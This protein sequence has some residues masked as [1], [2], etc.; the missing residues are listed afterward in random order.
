M[1]FCR[2]DCVRLDLMKIK[3]LKK[4]LCTLLVGTSEEVGKAACPPFCDR[5]PNQAATNSF[6]VEPPEGVEPSYF[7]CIVIGIRQESA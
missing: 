2:R 1:P 4:P 5:F 6:A 7:P 3:P